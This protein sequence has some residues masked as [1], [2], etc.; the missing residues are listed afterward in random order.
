M[1]GECFGPAGDRLPP[2]S[3]GV[4]VGGR[5][6]PASPHTGHRGHTRR[7]CAVRGSRRRRAPGG[8]RRRTL[9]AAEAGRGGTTPTGSRGGAGQAARRWHRIRVPRTPSPLEDRRGGE[10]P[11]GAPVP[12]MAGTAPAGHTTRGRAADRRVV[13][14]AWPTVASGTYDVVGIEGRCRR[15]AGHGGRSGAPLGACASSGAISMHWAVMQLPAPLVDLVLVH[16]LC[17]L[18]V[19]GHGAAFR[20]E[21]RLALPDALALERRFEMEEPL[22]WRGAV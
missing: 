3:R 2:G 15:T 11:T 22:L 14:R 1:P 9:P 12:G 16:E 17:H 4:G 7:R 5:R 19:P 10:R 13:H 18:R 8:G 6:A 20:R 21:V